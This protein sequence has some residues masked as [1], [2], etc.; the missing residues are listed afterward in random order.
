MEFSASSSGEGKK[1]KG[2]D[3]ISVAHG[4]SKASPANT[5]AFLPKMLAKQPRGVA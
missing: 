3:R 1:E 4:K 5:T 2:G